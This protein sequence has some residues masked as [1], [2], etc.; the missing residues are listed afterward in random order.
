M[1]GMKGKAAI[2]LLFVVGLGLLASCQLSHQGATETVVVVVVTATPT[3]QPTHTREIEPTVPPASLP[4]V[5]P[6]TVATVAPVESKIRPI[7]TPSGK[8]G[9]RV[10]DTFG[11]GDVFKV[12]VLG[13]REVE[14]KIGIEEIGQKTKRYVVVDVLA[15]NTTGSVQRFDP[16]PTVVL[17]D[18]TG[19]EVQV[20]LFF[21]EPHFTRGLLEG[22][23]LPHTRLRGELAFPV[24]EAFQVGPGMTVLFNFRG[25]MNKTVVHLPEGPGRV[26]VPETFPRDNVA[27]VPLGT[28][29]YVGQWQVT[30]WG[31]RRVEPPTQR[32]WAHLRP[33]RDYV[34]VDL[35]VENKGQESGSW[36]SLFYIALR[37]EA[38]HLY[39][40]DEEGH[41]YMFDGGNGVDDL[42]VPGQKKRG[43]LVFQ[44]LKDAG[45]FYLDVIPNG[46]YTRIGP[47]LNP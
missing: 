27:T 28:P 39:P 18:T 3:P 4:A 33:N 5:T 42:Y 1:V 40:V 10:G 9:L 16:I 23:L 36:T 21:G 34:L 43:M 2:L 6:S 8:P 30:V 45:E 19:Y 26:P 25:S 13:W 32:A 35:T 12:V 22:R 47:V 46:D 44:A 41:M 20:P 11:L 24:P 38:G 37:D 31:A 7:P 15:Y 29:A 17:V 14:E